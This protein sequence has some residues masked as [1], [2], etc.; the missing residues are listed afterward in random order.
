MQPQFITSNV[1]SA[2]VLPTSAQEAKVLGVSFYNGR[3]CKYRH[4]TVR[5]ASNK[6]CVTCM[7]DA[8]RKH[9]LTNL[10]KYAERMRE[11]RARHQ[12]EMRQYYS[13]YR[14]RNGEHIRELDRLAHARNPERK[15]LGVQQWREQYPERVKATRERRA[16]RNKVLQHLYYQVNRE[17]LR[18]QARARE[19][20]NRPQRN[21]R[22]TKRRARLHLAGGHYT[23]TDI[24]RL[25]VEQSG[26]CPYCL[27]EIVG[28]YHV[29]H[30]LPLSRGGSN[31]ASNIQ[32]LCPS[33]NHHKSNKTPSE[34]L[35][36]LELV[37]GVAI[38]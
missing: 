36:W 37:K 20:A 16:E 38:P 1:D 32:L 18:E 28:R 14:E 4:G 9:R 8:Q 23:V 30:I 29:D 26:K 31:E 27:T 15:R 24:E 6:N 19:L 11:Y 13:E 22:K 33:C 12:E 35:S 34:F 25:M 3:P 7:R 21:A 10:P 5:Y 2:Q 17:R